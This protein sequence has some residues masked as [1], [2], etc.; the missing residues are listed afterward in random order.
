[1]NLESKTK[2][3][4]MLIGAVLAAFLGL[5]GLIIALVGS[6]AVLALKMLWQAIMG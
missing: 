6:V 1:M 3:E 2:G 5:G 4:K